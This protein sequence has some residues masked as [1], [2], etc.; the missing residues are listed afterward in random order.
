MSVI[1]VYIYTASWLVVFAALFV[2][3]CYFIIIET[4]FIP[5]SYKYIVSTKK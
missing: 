4:A 1:Q 3:S 5:R 2:H